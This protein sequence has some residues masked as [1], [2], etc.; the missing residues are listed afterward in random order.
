MTRRKD[1]V[2]TLVTDFEYVVGSDGGPHLAR[3]S[4][5]RLGESDGVVRRSGRGW[6]LHV[7]Y[8]GR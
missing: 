2:G 1:R 4:E 5:A 3:P 8:R 7:R 6:G